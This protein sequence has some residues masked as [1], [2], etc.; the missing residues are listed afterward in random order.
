MSQTLPSSPSEVKKIHLH[1]LFLHTQ[2]PQM[3]PWVN[4]TYRT[5]PL[6]RSSASEKKTSHTPT[7]QLPANSMTPTRRISRHP[8]LPFH[9]LVPL[10]KHSRSVGHKHRSHSRTTPT[11]TMPSS[12]LSLEFVTTSTMVTCTSPKLKRSLG[13]VPPSDTKGCPAKMTKR[14]LLLHNSAKSSDWNLNLPLCYVPNH[15]SFSFSFTSII[16]FPHESL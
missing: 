3:L 13:L 9:V 16:P 14:Q 15:F 4:Y 11:P 6:P 10:F 12:P 2:L 5:Q 1:S 7:N 8:Y